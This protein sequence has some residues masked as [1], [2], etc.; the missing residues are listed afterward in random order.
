MGMR[1]S[2]VTVSA[3]GAFALVLTACG[4]SSSSKVSNTVPPNAGAIVD[5]KN[6]AFSPATVTIKAGQTVVWKFDDGSTAHNITG[7]GFRSPDRSSGTFSHTFSKA[8]DYKYDCTIHSGMNGE[9][10]VK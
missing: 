3:A 8:G 1:R 10:V 5:M 2:L 7:E 9:V 6:I 4:G